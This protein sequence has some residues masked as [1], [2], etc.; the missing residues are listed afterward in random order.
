[1][2]TAISPNSVSQ[3]RCTRR[4]NIKRFDKMAAKES[5]W[6]RFHIAADTRY[7][8]GWLAGAAAGVGAGGIGYF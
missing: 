6:Q 8:D 5:L 7:L 2:L 1:M 3:S 4:S